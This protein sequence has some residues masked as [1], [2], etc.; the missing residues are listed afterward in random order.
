M[1]ETA[2]TGARG[3]LRAIRETEVD[4]RRARTAPFPARAVINYETFGK[5]GEEERDG[6]TTVRSGY[7][8]GRRTAAVGYER[9]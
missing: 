1:K 5:T 8:V 2:K 7:R 9:L 6:G 4:K 3:F